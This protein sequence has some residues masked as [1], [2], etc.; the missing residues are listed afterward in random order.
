MNRIEINGPVLTIFLCRQ[1]S[2]LM[3]R[4]AFLLISF[5]GVCR[6][7]LAPVQGCIETDTK[8]RSALPGYFPGAAISPR[9][10]LTGLGLVS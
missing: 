6:H 3:H 8:N 7:K 4:K 1:D 9:P 5:A 2:C 10:A